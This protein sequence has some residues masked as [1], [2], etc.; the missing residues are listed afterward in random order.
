MI[1][2]GQLEAHHADFDKRST[3]I[4]VS[5]IEDRD[6]AAQ[7]QKDFP[8]LTV[9]SDHERGLSNAVDVIHQHSAPD[10][11]DSSAPTTILID[12]EGQV[13]WLYRPDR[14]LGRLSPGELAAAL[15]QHLPVRP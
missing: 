1:E 14:V 6:Q 7:T 5:S 3:R 13:R 11:G 10:G 2:L 15:D 12:R 4:V 8:H 9:L